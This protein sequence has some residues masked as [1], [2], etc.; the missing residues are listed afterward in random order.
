[1]G[2]LVRLFHIQIKMM[3]MINYMIAIIAIMIIICWCIK[4]TNDNTPTEIMDM[5][6]EIRGFVIFKPL[7]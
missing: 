1:M 3:N 7:E 5:L 4:S 6:M 2:Q